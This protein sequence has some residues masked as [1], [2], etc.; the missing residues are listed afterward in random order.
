[1]GFGIHSI[2]LGGGKPGILSEPTI[3]EASGMRKTA[4][5][6]TA[7]TCQSA[8]LK[9]NRRDPTR[10]L[11]IGG[12]PPAARGDVLHQDD[13]RRHDVHHPDHR[14]PIAEAEVLEG[15]RIYFEWQEIGGVIWVAVRHKVRGREVV[16]QADDCGAECEQQK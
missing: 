6:I 2:P 16:L 7:T 10:T 14:R 13:Q 15:V 11:V 12:L 5:T 1:M 3:I 8:T 9:P 4:L